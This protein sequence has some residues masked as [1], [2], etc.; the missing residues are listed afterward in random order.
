M[1]KHNRA[2]SVGPRTP[3]KRHHAGNIRDDS[4]P[5][6]ARPRKR[7]Y[8]DP[9]TPKVKIEEA[10]VDRFNTLAL[11]PWSPPKAP[12]KWHRTTS[13]TSFNTGY[14]SRSAT[15]FSPSRAR[16]R[17]RST[18][19]AQRTA[20]PSDI[21]SY[22]I[23]AYPRAHAER[24]QT[25]VCT[26][27]SDSS[28]ELITKPDK[29]ASS[30]GPDQHSAA[31]FEHK[32]V[33]AG[34]IATTEEGEPIES[35][36]D[37]ELP[38]SDSDSD[39]VGRD[40]SNDYDETMLTTSSHASDGTAAPVRLVDEDYYVDIRVRL[41]HRRTGDTLCSDH[42]PVFPSFGAWKLRVLGSDPGGLL[43]HG[44]VQKTFET[45]VLKMGEVAEKFQ[46]HMHAKVTARRDMLA[47]LE[48]P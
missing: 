11:V 6:T 20:R 31:E 35:W 16:Q 33:E 34:A 26:S 10:Q 23:A 17:S 42:L 46:G 30:R 9:R 13:L 14:R 5:P 12:I 4:A 36:G 7:P 43:K 1:A 27:L 25:S 8:Q 32:P 48:D 41:V 21:T 15:P 39:S 18:T 2:H 24:R 3:T 47:R 44:E 45:M 29:E 37:F 40:S 19:A 22:T 38:G 28:V